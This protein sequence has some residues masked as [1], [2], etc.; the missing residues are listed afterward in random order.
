VGGG[1]GAHHV[2]IEMKR[3]TPAVT[4]VVPK[5]REFRGQFTDLSF[6]LRERIE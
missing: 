4:I 3:T 1:P 6:G 2:G 5:Q